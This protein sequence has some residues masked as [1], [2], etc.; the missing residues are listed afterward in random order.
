MKSK[1]CSNCRTTFQPQRIGQR[2]CSP[3]CAIEAVKSEREA[4]NR[5]KTA[6]AK[7]EM[8]TRRDW[9]KLAQISFNQFVRERDKEQPCISC[10]RHHQGQNHAGHYLSTGA[11]PELRFNENNVH[12][13]CA[14]CN[15]H[16]SGNISLYRIA[17]IRKIGIESVEYLEGPHEPAKWTI[18]E[19]KEII[20]T[21]KA[22]TKEL[23]NQDK[24]WDWIPQGEL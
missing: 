6:L 19:L 3:K 11:R 8:R 16:K 14:P 21:Y 2:V 12:L 17:L 10:G 1:K 4:T 13:Q 22:K 7:V 23:R 15:N 20:A 5:K 18:D 24:K 9:L